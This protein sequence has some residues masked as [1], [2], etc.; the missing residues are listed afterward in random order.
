MT[1]LFAKRLRVPAHVLVR[2]LDGESVILNLDS[3]NYFGLDAVGTRMIAVLSTSDRIQG[4]YDILA[5]E[6]NAD[7]ERLGRDVETFI[8]GLVERGLVEVSEASS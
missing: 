5:A 2:E 6:Y 4:A 7:P 8:D 1:R 3:G